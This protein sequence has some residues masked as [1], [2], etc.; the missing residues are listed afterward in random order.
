MEQRNYKG[1][2]IK[3]EISKNKD[4]CFLAIKLST[5]KNIFCF[6]KNELVKKHWL[7]K[8]REYIFFDSQKNQ[9]KYYFLDK[10]E[11]SITLEEQRKEE[12]QKTQINQL[13]D[14]WKIRNLKRLEKRL[15]R[16]KSKQE[17]HKLEYWALMIV[18]H[19]KYLKNKTLKP[20]ETEEKELIGFISENWSLFGELFG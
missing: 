6:A 14:K 20:T 12:I 10:A 1:L 15:A 8:G 18:K 11:R 16:L 9:G 7:V 13:A 5:G 3:K 17:T 19:K 4:N 2:L